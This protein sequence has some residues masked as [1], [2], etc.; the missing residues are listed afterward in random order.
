MLGD[1][2]KFTLRLVFFP[3]LLVLVGGELGGEG[4]TFLAWNFRMPPFL[5]FDVQT[6]VSMSLHDD[7][8]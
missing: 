3:A 5:W 8:V 1:K 6:H 4:I 7:F 2:T